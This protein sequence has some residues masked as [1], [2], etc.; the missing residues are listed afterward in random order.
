VAV[1]VDAGVAAVE[2]GHLIG[3]FLI[4]NHFQIRCN[5]LSLP[6]LLPLLLEFRFGFYPVPEKE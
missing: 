2:S 4:M 5:T 3:F 6:Q 1:P